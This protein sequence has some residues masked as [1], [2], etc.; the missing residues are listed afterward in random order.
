MVS[1]EPISGGEG[2]EIL[3]KL[4]IPAENL[5][6]FRRDI[7][8]FILE[9]NAEMRFEFHENGRDTYA[10]RLQEWIEGKR[11]LIQSKKTLSQKFF[12]K[13]VDEKVK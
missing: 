11:D 2:I 10:V 12:E 3:I 6:T 1:A 7:F 5:E 13:K 9:A 4:D 8:K